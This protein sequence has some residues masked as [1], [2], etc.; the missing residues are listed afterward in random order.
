MSEF[1][2]KSDSVDLLLMILVKL[3][4]SRV[5]IAEDHNQK[6]QNK[7]KNKE[8]KAQLDASCAVGAAAAAVTI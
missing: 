5:Q 4:F 7:K 8:I 3:R 6:H 2:P 1:C